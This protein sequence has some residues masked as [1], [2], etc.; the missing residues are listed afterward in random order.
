[1][2][3]FRFAS[4][5]LAAFMLLTAGCANAQ[6]VLDPEQ[7]SLSFVSIKAQNVAEVHQ[8]RQLSGSLNGAGSVRV[9]VALDSVDTGIEIRDERM[10][11]MLFDTQ[12][13]PVALVEVQLPEAMD[14]EVGQSA[15]YQVPVTLTLGLQTASAVA[16]AK[17]SC[18]EDGQFEAISIQPV[19]LSTTLLGLDRGVEA[20][21]EVAGLSSISSAVPVTFAVTFV[22]AD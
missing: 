4:P 13:H 6:W 16:T 1:M 18:Y 20:L 11:S 17:V 15:V 2:R 9:E 21:R 10:R 22:K 5:K 3:V 7:S 14:L 8:F 19:L 12:D